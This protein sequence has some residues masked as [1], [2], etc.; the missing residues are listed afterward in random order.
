MPILYIVS[1]AYTAL[2][3]YLQ[4]P[5]DLSETFTIS[6][7]VSPFSIDFNMHMNNAEFLHSMELGRWNMSI[8]AGL[9]K[10][11]TENNWAPVLGG[12]S[13]RFRRSLYP[14]QKYEISCRMLGVD[15]RWLYVEHVLSSKGLFI[16]KGIG[17]VCCVDKADGKLVPMR[18]VMSKM[19]WSEAEVERR[20]I[21]M[22]ARDSAEVNTFIAHDAT[23]DWK[24]PM[25]TSSQ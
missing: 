22:A 8:R 18:T 13:F 12:I 11:W 15:E 17:R 7:R 9:V 23:L 20:M 24:P 4:G 21:E 3:A 25:P 5:M 1:V 10:L 19:G 16:G 6:R 14:F 2:E